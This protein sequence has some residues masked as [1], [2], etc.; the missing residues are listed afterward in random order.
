MR[1]GRA[2]PQENLRGFRVRRQSILFDHPCDRF[3]PPLGAAA[4]AVP[5]AAQ[6]C[7]YA[8]KGVALAAEIPKGAIL[9]RGLRGVIPDS[10][11]GRPVGQDQRSTARIPLE[12]V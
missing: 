7:G 2:A 12:V 10:P 8:A 1:L 9:I 3:Q 4:R 5:A 11:D 6:S